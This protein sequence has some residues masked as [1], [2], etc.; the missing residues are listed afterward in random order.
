MKDV[1][2][3]TMIYKATF[4]SEEAV[5]RGYSVKGCRLGSR[6]SSGRDVERPSA[7]RS[8]LGRFRHGRSLIQQIQK[9]SLE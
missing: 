7:I 1:D 8:C 4:A 5:C 9:S 2:A 3:A 6:W